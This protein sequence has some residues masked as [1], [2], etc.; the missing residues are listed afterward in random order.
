M[1]QYTNININGNNKVFEYLIEYNS[2]EY[3]GHSPIYYHM[4][5][6]I[7]L[8][9]NDSILVRK[10]NE[11]YSYKDKELLNINNYNLCNIK[12]FFPE[13]SINSYDNNMLYILSVTTWVCGKRICL[14]NYILNR[15]DVLVSPNA[16]TRDSNKYYEYISIDILD[17]RQIAYSDTWKDFRTNICESKIIDNYELNNDGSQ[18]LFTLYPVR[19]ENK[20]YYIDDKY[21]GGQNS[22]NISNEKDY[23]TLESSISHNNGVILNN[24]IIFNHDYD[25]D[26]VLYFKETYGVDLSSIK[27]ETVI[28]DSENIYW[29]YT[30][31]ITKYRGSFKQYI[32]NYY[33]DDKSYIDNI[34]WNDWYNDI[35]KIINTNTNLNSIG[36]KWSDWRD[37]M[38]ILSS[39]TFYDKSHQELLYIFSN[40]IILT[41]DLFSYLCNNDDILSINLNK[42]TIK[43]M[44]LYNINAVNKI[45]NEVIHID[46]PDNSKS[47]IIQPVFFKVKDATNIIIHPA[48]TEN[49]CINLDDYKSKVDSFTI[50][51]ENCTFKQI[52]SNSYGIIF[53]I[54]G[55]NLQNKIP[56]GIYYILNQ[57]NELVTTGKYIY[58][59]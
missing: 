47:N 28:K 51:I 48:V 27:Y 39:A 36:F 14:G 24:N 13:Y 37:G 38:S 57:D 31:I 59:Q 43:E 6:N 12:L 34:K 41:K 58:E 33:S 15:L 42:D 29:C 21:D 22:I 44:K 50:Q 1:K 53:K 40:D 20:T 52:G 3:I 30:N 7:N 45:V 8:F 2:S 18:I 25:L 10:E 56:K 19:Y 26:I 23:L 16:I 11:W 35:N 46:K 9:L 4:D 54:L 55:K 49:I 32:E 17:P 5:D